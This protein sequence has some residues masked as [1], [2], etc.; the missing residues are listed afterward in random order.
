[1]WRFVRMLL[2]CCYVL[3]GCGCSDE[4]ASAE[5]AC[6]ACNST[7]IV[8]S[9]EWLEQHRSD[10]DV[11]LVDTRSLEAFSAGHIPGALHLDAGKLRRTVDG[12][13][14]QVTDADAAREVFSQAAIQ[15]D[16]L[17][18]VYDADV[19]TTPAR[20]V[21]TLAH[22]GHKR[23][24]LL[25]GGLTS[26]RA[27]Q[28]P[29]TQ[30]EAPNGTPA[31]SRSDY[32][33][34]HTQPSLRVEAADVLAS[35]EDEAYQLVDARSSAEFAAGHIPGA[36]SVDWTRNVR[37]GALLFDEELEILYAGLSKD[38]TT[39]AYCQTG[40]RASVTYLMLRKLGFKDVRL[41]DGSWAEWSAGESYPKSP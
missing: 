32:V 19:N 18:V 11:Q 8:V 27:T 29:I 5:E 23:V 21:W 12:V 7:G 6:E 4:A 40:S 35:L 36:Y 13:A 24:A 2:P 30:G 15:N 10:A 22:F 38:K 16:T 25:D 9:A 37:D 1:M 31:Q 28:G 14:G 33:L 39:V 3:I 26:W 17:V 41:Y 20:V 34:T